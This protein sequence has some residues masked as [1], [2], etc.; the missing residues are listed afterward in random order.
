M[1]LWGCGAVQWCAWVEIGSHG[2][3]LVVASIDPS[4]SRLLDILSAHSVQAAFF[5]VGNRVATY[6]SVLRRARAEGHFVAHHSQLHTDMALM[7]SSVFRAEVEAAEAAIRNEA[8]ITTRLIR[9][10]FGSVLSHQVD[11]LNDM[12][13][14]VRPCERRT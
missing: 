1:I 7:T 3:L 11:A 5:V 2:W 6:G 8:C 9:P 12:G 14:M 13:Y 4:T 10:P